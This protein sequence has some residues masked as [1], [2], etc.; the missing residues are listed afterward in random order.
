MSTFIFFFVLVNCFVV[1]NCQGEMGN[2]G[3]DGLDGLPGPPGPPG[4][5]GLHGDGIPG[6]PGMPGVAGLR[7]VDG[8]PG[9]DG[10]KGMTL[11]IANF[12]SDTDLQYTTVMDSYNSNSSLTQLRCYVLSRKKV[13]DCN[14]LFS[15]VC[16]AMFYVQVLLFV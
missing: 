3:L 7:G 16:S 5:H 6:F 2:M 12:H 9:P 13:N 4:T 8:L 11:F 1:T 14:G 15:C 10:P